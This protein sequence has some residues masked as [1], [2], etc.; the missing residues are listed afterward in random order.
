[1]KILMT[2]CTARH[3]N[4]QR[5]LYKYLAGSDVIRETLKAAGHEVDHRFVYRDEYPTIARKYDRVL[6]GMVK[7]N[8]L[9]SVHINQAMSVLNAFPKKR[10]LIYYDDWCCFQIPSG[11]NYALNNWEKWLKWRYRNTKQE[12][13]PT[14]KELIVMEKMFHEL[15]HQAPKALAYMYDY[16]DLDAFKKKVLPGEI[17]RYDP[18]CMLKTVKYKPAPERERAWISA[19]LHKHDSWFESMAPWTWPVKHFG[20]KKRGQPV[21]TEEQVTEMYRT[22]WGM[23]T[24]GYPD[25]MLGWW[26]VRM[27]HAARMK[28]INLVDRKEANLMGAATPYHLDLNDV[29]GQPDGQLQEIADA[30]AKF[31]LRK[32]WTR[33]RLLST[34]T[35]AIQ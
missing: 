2:G 33:K 7:A 32:T 1:M 6:C 31:F 29:E 25:G 15:L 3:V 9:M 18:S 14:A 30:Q 13:L 28:C 17:I 4:S 16:A 12:N 10:R 23:I 21:L 26:R 5:L 34:L 35:T 24:H 22:H 19:T 27:V 20:N 8:S 11:T